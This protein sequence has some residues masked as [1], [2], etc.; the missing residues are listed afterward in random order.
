MNNIFMGMR[1]SASGLTAE[2]MRMDVIANNI[3]NIET[4]RTENGGPYKRKIVTFKENLERQLDSTNNKMQ[5]NYKGVKVEKI[6]EDNAP[7]KRYIIHPIQMQMK[8]DMF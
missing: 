4:T 1:I 6:T 7:F 8:M 3:A 2:R 5:E